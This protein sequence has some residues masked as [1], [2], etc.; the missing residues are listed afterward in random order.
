MLLGALDRDAG[1]EI[2][3]VPMLLIGLGIGALAS[4]LGSVTVSAVP[5]DES[6]EVGGVQNTAT[7][8]GASLRDW[9]RARS[10]LRR[11]PRPSSPT[12]S[13]AGDPRERQGPCGGGARGRDSLHLRRRP[14]DRPRGSGREAET[15]E[16][17]LDAYADAR[18]GGLKAALAI[19]AVLAVV[20]LFL[21]Q[22]PARRPGARLAD[23]G[24]LRPWETPPVAPR[25]PRSRAR[26]HRKSSATESAAIPMIAEKVSGAFR[27]VSI[28]KATRTTW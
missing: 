11:S 24:G 19:L 10:S 26:F 25:P 23:R 2:V 18:L 28:A 12:C 17:A 6:P 9:W 14:R 16:A 27:S 13:K 8:L 20:A 21:A 3:F 5:D 15:T 4:Q 1:A 7:N 22:R